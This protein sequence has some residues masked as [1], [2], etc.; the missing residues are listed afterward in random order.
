MS[1]VRFRFDGDLQT[2]LP[3]RAGD[4]GATGGEAQTGEAAAPAGELLGGRGQLPGHPL[5]ERGSQLKIGDILTIKPNFYTEYMGAND[6]PRP[7]QVVLHTPRRSVL[8]GGV[9]ERRVF[10]AGDVFPL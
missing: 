9:P 7:A 8:C 2:L 4:S 10:L 3:D 1:Y 6:Q 5:G